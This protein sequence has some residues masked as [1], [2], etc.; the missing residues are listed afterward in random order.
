MTIDVLWHL[1]DR[2]WYAR[3]PS[4]PADWVKVS[5]GHPVAD[6]TDAELLVG[7]RP[8]FGMLETRG[9]TLRRLEPARRFPRDA[10]EST[11]R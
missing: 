3:G 7:V 6:V 9:A 2:C 11:A 8:L 10:A 1:R 5:L 4:R